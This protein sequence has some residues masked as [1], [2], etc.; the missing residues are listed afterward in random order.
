[1]LQEKMLRQ[2]M[3]NLRRSR[4]S[5]VTPNSE[6]SNPDYE[7]MYHCQNTPLLTFL[8]NFLL[9]CV[10]FSIFSQL[11]KVPTDISIAYITISLVDSYSFGQCY[12]IHLCCAD[13]KQHLSIHQLLAQCPPT[14]GWGTESEE[15]NRE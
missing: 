2:I 9:T 11:P 14:K 8:L 6:N 7:V 3:F 15:Q 1:M 5:V 13:P 4:S 10:Q 12:Y